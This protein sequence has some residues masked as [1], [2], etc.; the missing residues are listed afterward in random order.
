MGA[1]LSR[2][3]QSSRAMS[4]P[5]AEGRV[6]TSDQ[7][8]G[9][10]PTN[11]TS[12]PHITSPPSHAGHQSHFR[13]PSSG[14]SSPRPSNEHRFNPTVGPSQPR[15]SGITKLL[16]V[17]NRSSSSGPTTHSWSRLTRPRRGGGSNGGG[18]HY[19]PPSPRLDH[20]SPRND[21]SPEPDEIDMDQGLDIL[22]R[23]AAD[24]APYEDEAEAGRGQGAAAAAGAHRQ[25]RRAE[26]RGQSTAESKRD[27]DRRE[28]PS[29]RK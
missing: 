22:A 26:K 6:Y 16:N 21:S 29:K 11:Y 4:P 7:N 20:P 15:R 24:E 9:G 10:P 3:A 8:Y 27:R 13:R 28:H 5:F 1:S 18:G 14:T 23:V 17:F 12:N 25:Q 19:Y 2:P